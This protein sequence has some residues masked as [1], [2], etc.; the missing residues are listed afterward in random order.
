MRFNTILS[1]GL[2]IVLPF[3]LADDPSHCASHEEIIWSC[4]S[5]SKTYEVCASKNLSATSGY[6]QYRAG[7]VGKPEFI[8]PSELVSPRGLFHYQLLAQGAQL[9]F[10]HGQYQ[11]DLT[12][13]LKGNAAIWVSKG[14]ENTWL[15]VN[16][17]KWSD[18]LT[19][20]ST[21]DRFKSIG[22]YE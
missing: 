3:A 22:I 13:P 18:T 7:R 12:E 10:K 1:L 15:A 14:D 4:S 17:Q 20:T 11:Y 6:M 5:K 8:F 2:V 9:S 19:L 16:C 21:L